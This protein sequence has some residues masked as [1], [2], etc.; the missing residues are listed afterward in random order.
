MWVWELDADRQ[1]D[2]IITPQ[3]ERSKGVRV[4]KN[5]QLLSPDS[6]RVFIKNRFTKSFPLQTD[7]FYSEYFGN[8]LYIA[9]GNQIKKYRVD[10]EG[11]I[12]LVL[13]KTFPFVIRILRKS[14]KNLAVATYNR[15]TYPVDTAS[16]ELKDPVTI[17]YCRKKCVGR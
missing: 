9:T 14:G 6:V 12:S 16:L 11:N 8:A 2:G 17:Q 7:F 3:Y 15:T 10:S 1:T 4:H 5:N 13:Q